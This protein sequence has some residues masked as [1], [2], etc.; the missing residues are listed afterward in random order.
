[1][2]YWRDKECPTDSR[3]AYYEGRR[4]E[5]WQRNPYEHGRDAFASHSCREAHDEWERGHRAAEYDREM[6]REQEEAERRRQQRREYE[7]QQEEAYY[8]Q[9]AA[10]EQAY[11]EAMQLQQLDSAHKAE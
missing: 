7:R 6:Q 1:M 10:E 8:V 3:D 9:Q 11:Y 5:D 2:S 4:S